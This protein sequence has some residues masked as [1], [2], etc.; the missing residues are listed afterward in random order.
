[1]VVCKD[2]LIKNEFIIT[3]EII[4]GYVNE[5]K[6][7]LVIDGGV[8]MGECLLNV[9]D[10]IFYEYAS[11]DNLLMLPDDYNTITWICFK[12]IESD[13]RITITKD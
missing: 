11:K 12:I 9:I 4:N 6:E 13:E 5:I 10:D 1:M 7:K 2:T 3:N 8:V